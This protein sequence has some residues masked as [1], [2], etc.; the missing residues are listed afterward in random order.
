MYS[1]EA[2][3]ANIM[4]IAKMDFMLF[5]L[6]ERVKTGVCSSSKRWKSKSENYERMEVQ[7]EATGSMADELA[8]P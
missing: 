6:K 7:N 2:A 3:A 8:M 1:A 5:Y 4:E